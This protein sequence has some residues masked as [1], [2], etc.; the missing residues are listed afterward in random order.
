[1]AIL[2]SFFQGAHVGTSWQCPV[3]SALPGS[4]DGL[5]GD[6]RLGAACP[7]MGLGQGDGRP[8]CASLD[9]GLRL[10]SRMLE[11]LLRKAQHEEG[12]DW[13]DARSP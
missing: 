7:D 1:M 2:P 6:G 4:A 5:P 13:E 12:G 8:A 3:R 9:P 10:P 11:T